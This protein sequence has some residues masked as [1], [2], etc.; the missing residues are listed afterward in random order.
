[1]KIVIDFAAFQLLQPLV[2]DFIEHI[3]VHVGDPN[4]NRK[5]LLFHLFHIFSVPLLEIFHHLFVFFG[6]FERV[7]FQDLNQSIL[8]LAEVVLNHIHGNSAGW[9]IGSV[10]LLAGILA[11]GC[12]FMA[13]FVD[14]EGDYFVKAISWF[15]LSHLYN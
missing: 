4:Q 7:H 3:F 15:L 9:K 1:M 13:V 10:Y 5:H 14:L 11:D 8:Y 2:L 12:K 6:E